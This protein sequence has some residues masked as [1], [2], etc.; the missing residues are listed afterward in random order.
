MKPKYWK[1]DKDEQDE[2]A[3][4]EVAEPAVAKKPAKPTMVSV[5]V[6]AESGLDHGG[7]TYTKGERLDVSP[8]QKTILEQHNFI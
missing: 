7:K 8:Q 3:T 5:V 6:K 1:A 2:Q 4:V